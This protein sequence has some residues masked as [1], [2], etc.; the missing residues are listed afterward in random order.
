MVAHIALLIAGYS[1]VS[2]TGWWTQTVDFFATY[3]AMLLAV[4]GVGLLVMVVVTSIRAARRKLRYESWHLIHLYAYLGVGLALPHQLWKGAD[5]ISSP[6]TTAYW[7]TLWIVALACVLCYRLLLPLV[8]SMR[9]DLRVVQVAPD[10][11][12]GVGVVLEGRALDKLGARAG[13]FFVFRFLAGPGWTRGNPFSLAF[14]PTNTHLAIAARVVGDGTRRMARMKPGTRVLIEG[15]YGT[16]T[17][18]ARTGRKLLMLGAGAG[19]APLVSLLQSEP[20][21]PG[22]ATLVTRD[23]SPE[24]ALLT[25]PIEDLITGREL[26][27]YRLDGPRTASGSTWRPKTYERWS[28]GDLLRSMVSG[29]ISAYDVFLCGPPVWMDSLRADLKALGVPD[30][31]IHHES[32]E[33]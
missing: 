26:R 21:A 17:G 30:E 32:F 18:E 23:H 33:I 15:P 19:V 24:E 16:M 27:W 22:E 2:N 9:H 6:L 14:A 7:W 28:G 3:P 5:F 13:Q 12:R 10:G 1:A 11:T 20:W 4:A 25:G 31:R 8:R 29:P